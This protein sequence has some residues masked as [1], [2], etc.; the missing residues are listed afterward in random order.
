MPR[1]TPTTEFQL[2]RRRRR[3][4]AAMTAAMAMGV[5]Y[6]AWTNSYA[7]F[8]IAQPD[9]CV[10]TSDSGER[11]VDVATAQNFVAQ[12]LENKELLPKAS[13]T[14][15]YGIDFSEGSKTLS[16]RG[17]TP[18][19]ETLD[20]TIDETFGRVP[21]GGYA[22]GGVT[23]GHIPGSAHYEGRAIDY[24]FRPYDVPEN[25][26]AG[27]QLALWAVVHAG[28]L[29]I[30]TIIFDDHIWTANRSF[31]GWREYVHPSGDRENPIL[32]HLDHVHI[33]VK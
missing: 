29:N 24:F 18:S 5:A 27:W 3:T 4:I 25:R 32:R 12:S 33:D 6:V 11:I 20:I 30:D 8:G 16:E 14:C 23:E 19:A 7:L 21:D 26:K 1:Y 2:R 9:T 15:T 10:I 17:L 22:P 13:I 31:E 28:D